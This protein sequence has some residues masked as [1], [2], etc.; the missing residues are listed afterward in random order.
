MVQL[1][2][3]VLLSNV[4]TPIR[5][6]VFNCGFLVFSH[7]ARFWSYV[8]TVFCLLFFLS[9]SESFRFCFIVFFY[10]I[11]I[12]FFVLWHRWSTPLL[13]CSFVHRPFYRTGFCSIFLM[14]SCCVCALC[15]Y[16]RFIRTFIRTCHLPANHVVQSEIYI[17]LSF[18][19]Y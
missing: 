4:L 8:L 16:P 9:N 14:P 12:P 10:F 13:I 6:V 7:S 15:L 11:H 17:Y 18:L 1:S 5:S 19:F 2:A 3:H